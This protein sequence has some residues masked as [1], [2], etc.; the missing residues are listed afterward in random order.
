[1]FKMPTP[2]EHIHISAKLRKTLISDYNSRP[3]YIPYFKHHNSI[4]INVK[5]FRYTQ[6]HTT[7][8]D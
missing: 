4:I 7:H 8:Y 2:L 5:P 3:Y 6:Y 1:M